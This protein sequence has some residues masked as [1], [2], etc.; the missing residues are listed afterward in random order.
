MT[1]NIRALNIRALINWGA[2]DNFIDSTFVE[3][4]NFKVLPKSKTISLASGNFKIPI[5]GCCQ[6]K[7]DLG[8]R[9]RYKLSS[10]VIPNLVEDVVLGKTF[11]R[12]HREVR[13]K[14]N[15]PEHSL[16]V[17]SLTPL[18]AE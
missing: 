2:D 16:N 7:L 1:A 6:A 4:L 15:R 12:L 11:M 8:G 17:C 3:V 10:N 18:K 5:S 13:F 9:H 14:Y